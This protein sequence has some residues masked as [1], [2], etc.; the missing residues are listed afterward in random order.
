MNRGMKDEDDWVGTPPEGFHSRD[1]ADPEFWR[2]QYRK[3]MGLAGAGLLVVVLLLV[4][5]ILVG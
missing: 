2:A 3:Q 4:V 1:K 5:V